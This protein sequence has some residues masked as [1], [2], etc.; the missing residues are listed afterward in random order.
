NDE[1]T[2]G[3][4]IKQIHMF[5]P[6]LVG[7]TRSPLQPPSRRVKEM[8]RP[9]PD[10]Q[11]LKLYRP[12]HKA[13]LSFRERMHEFSRIIMRSLFT[14]VEIMIIYFEIGQ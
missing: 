11:N 2:L 6:F 4:V 7:P 10:M 1:Y 5:S 8:A 14:D 9:N 3:L 12:V 13:N